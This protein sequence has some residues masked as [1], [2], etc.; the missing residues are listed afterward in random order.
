M[1]SCVCLPGLKAACSSSSFPSMAI[2]N[3]ASIILEK[4]FSTTED[5]HTALNFH[6]WMSLPS[7][8]VEL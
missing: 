3:L 4:A 1:G 5:K 7:Y 2:L 8:T 6:I